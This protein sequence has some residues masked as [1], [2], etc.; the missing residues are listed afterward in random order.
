MSLVL[1]TVPSRLVVSRPWGHLSGLGQARSLYLDELPE[2]L[3]QQEPLSLHTACMPGFWR[4]CCV[5]GPP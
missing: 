2:I 4:G 1:V 5:Q 3:G